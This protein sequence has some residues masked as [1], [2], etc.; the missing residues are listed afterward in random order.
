M[1]I[2]RWRRF[3]WDLLKLPPLENRLPAYFT[4]REATR[5]ESKVVRAM[6]MT[7]FALDSAWSDALK[8]FSERMENQIE[9]TFQ[10][11][12]SPAIVVTHG[13][14]VIAASVLSTEMEAESH[15]VSGPCVLSEYC[16]RGIGTALLHH[17]LRNLR[18]A[19]FER[20]LG[21][22]KQ[23]VPACKF[24]YPKFG[25]ASAAYDYEPHAVGT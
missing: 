8:V 19:G 3:T 16:N 22:T 13:V 4:F 25:S 7:S 20:V 5:E 1:K 6:I 12:S 17:S 24:V 21:I 15:L 11:E 10:R 18:Q 14:R 23:N 9:A 2:V